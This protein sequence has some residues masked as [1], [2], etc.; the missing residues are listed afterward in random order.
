MVGF[1]YCYEGK[2]KAICG[3]HDAIQTLGGYK[4]ERIDGKALWYDN[5]L[6]PEVNNV[7]FHYSPAIV[8]YWT[9]NLTSLKIGDESQA[10][11]KTVGSGAIFDHAS[12][13]RGA[14]LSLDAYERLITLSG[15]KPITL[16]KLLNNGNQSFYEVECSKKE[17]LPPLKYQFAGHAKEWEIVASNYVDDIGN[18][19]CVLNVRTLGYGDMVAGNFGETF[20][21]DKYIM[22]DFETLK[23]GIADLKY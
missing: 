14:P 12:Y 2:D 23:V 1:H 22:F 21:K 19:T 5:I 9:L 8:N 18:D 7:D 6:F 15:A 20:A 11:N 17:S 13:G 10:V 3:G 16:E 4:K